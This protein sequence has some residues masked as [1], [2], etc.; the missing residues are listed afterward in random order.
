MTDDPLIR[1]EDSESI[2]VEAKRQRIVSSL[3]V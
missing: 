3:E 2:R 1:V